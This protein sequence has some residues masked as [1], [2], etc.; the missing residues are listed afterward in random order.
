LLDRC[1]QNVTSEQIK[2]HFKD[3]ETKLNIILTWY[4]QSSMG[5]GTLHAMQHQNDNDDHNSDN[6]SSDS[7]AV[8]YVDGSDEANFLDKYKPHIL[9]YW[10]LMGDFKLLKHCN[11]CL[12]DGGALSDNVSVTSSNISQHTSKLCQKANKKRKCRE[13]KQDAFQNL[14]TQNLNVISVSEMRNAL[15]NM[16]KEK[17]LAKKEGDKDLVEFLTEQI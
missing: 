5:A 3:T 15:V 17:C 10:H 13:K 11:V 14:V 2:E 8:Q 7:D 12:K 16:M 9:Y 1:P 6:N 4:E